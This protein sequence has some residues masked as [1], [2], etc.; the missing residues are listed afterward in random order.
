MHAQ[1]L[2]WCKRPSGC[3]WQVSDIDNFDAILRV[4]GWELGTV[5]LDVWE[6][7]Y[8]KQAPEKGLMCTYRAAWLHM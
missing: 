2:F 5:L 8:W 1:S 4:R 6:Q 3:C 7:L